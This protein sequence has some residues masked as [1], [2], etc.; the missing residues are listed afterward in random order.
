MCCGSPLAR[1]AQ[2]AALL[3]LGASACAG[4]HAPQ[5]AAPAVAAARGT[6]GDLDQL[7]VG[8]RALLIDTTLTLDE[9]STVTE[10]HLLRMSGEMAVAGSNALAETSQEARDLALQA[11]AG[12]LVGREDVEVLEANKLPTGEVTLRARVVWD[13]VDFRGDLRLVETTL[14]V[15]AA[16]LAGLAPMTVAPL[17]A[18]Q[19]QGKPAVTPERWSGTRVL[20]RSTVVL[21]DGFRARALAPALD[22]AQDNVS[23]ARTLVART[24]LRI[25]GT[26]AFEI[27]EPGISSARLEQLLD[28]LKP[29]DAE[30]PAVEVEM[31]TE[32]LASTRRLAE[33]LAESRRLVAAHPGRAYYRA[34]QA[35]VLLVLGLMDAART[36]ARRAATQAPDR[37]YGHHVLARTLESDSFG[38]RF[39][40][41]YDRAGAV[42]ARRQHFKVTG[43]EGRG[44]FELAWLLAHDELG[45]T[46]GPEAPVQEILSLTRGLEA[47]GDEANLLRTQTLL[48]MHRGAEAE[49][50]ARE[51][52]TGASHVPYL[53]AAI[54]LARGAEAA[55]AELP[56]LSLSGDTAGG[57]LMQA[58]NHLLRVE[59]YPEAA[60]LVAA[61]ARVASRLRREA[62]ALTRLRRAKDRQRDPR[63]A[64]ETLARLQLA[65]ARPESFRK[66]APA[67]LDARLVAG[68]PFAGDEL[69]ESVCRMLL[70]T[71]AW[72]P[73]QWNI[74]HELTEDLEV[75]GDE[76]QG[77]RLRYR[78]PP[79]RSL[80]SASM[81][82][83]TGTAPPRLLGRGHSVAADEALRLTEAGRLKDAAAWL[84]WVREAA[85]PAVIAGRLGAAAE[86]LEALW[87][88]RAPLAAAAMREAS[89]GVAAYGEASAARAVAVLAPALATARDADRRLALARPLLAALA[90]AGDGPQA[91]RTADAVEALS[92]RDGRLVG[93]RAGAA[94]A[95]GNCPKALAI[96]R[97]KPPAPDLEALRRHASIAATC[98]AFDEAVAAARKAVAMP[99]AGPSDFNLLAWAACAGGQK[100]D[101][102]AAA[103]KAAQASGRN[104]PSILHTLA[105]AAALAGELG[106][107]RD[108][109]LDA[110]ARPPAGQEPL[111]PDAAWLV[112]GAIAESVGMRDDAIA[113]YR[114]VLPSKD[115]VRARAA[116]STFQ[117]A[118]RR[119]A[120]LAKA[121]AADRQ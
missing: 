42:T 36:E 6:N 93:A 29:G 68:R 73:T 109:L 90:L 13:S 104:S 9:Y 44:A 19:T 27:R 66:V 57:P 3:L 105:Y 31:V 20:H 2:V 55:L 76:R 25:E 92:Q 59:A 95:A 5:G 52:L 75:A 21:P 15:R 43:P 100:T 56:A 81:F 51:H 38:R 33:A 46:L 117:V 63:P 35:H 86:A 4:A 34:K 54:T 22:L 28:T 120:E 84:A 116:N 115:K 113:A 37:A 94:V 7:M 83:F 108:A 40:P 99:G 58:T 96:A 79:A 64:V 119:L 47:M 16:V 82:Y 101:A 48:R 23:L 70:V 1:R 14:G 41:G 91:D 88:P 17:V 87:P 50:V 26:L 78:R 8:P 106:E 32:T 49:A 112:V 111:N 98:G 11:L 12:L 110:L 89:A 39:G 72:P 53:L 69:Y 65:C 80:V 103:R 71:T 97:P 114:R 67:L 62:D 61:G 85:V 45:R 24:P 77:Y 18:A 118:Q 102:L 74:D 107:A 10:E 30:G 60:A 121:T